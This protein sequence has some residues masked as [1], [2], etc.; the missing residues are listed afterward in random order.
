VVTTTLTGSWQR[1]TQTATTPGTLPSGNIGLFIRTNGSE[2][3]TF[4]IDNLQLEQGSSA[5]TWVVG[6]PQSGAAVLQRQA[7]IIITDTGTGTIMF[8]GYVSKLS[9]ETWRVQP[10]VKVDCHDYWQDLDRVQCNLIFNYAADTA[11]ISQVL[12]TYAPWIDTSLVNF[13]VANYT[14]PLR[15]FRAKSVMQ[16]LQTIADVV[17]FDVWVD[18]NKK[19]HYQAP[20]SMGT[21]AFAISDTPNGVSTF[22]AKFTKYEQDDNAIVNRG[23]FYGGKKASDD[24]TQNLSNQCTGS[25]T[26]FTVAY[27]PRNS[28]DGK[29]HI[30]KNGVDMVVG[31]AFGTGAAN[32]LKS[33]GGSADCILNVDA[34][35]I[36]WSTAPLANPSRHPTPH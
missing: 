6:G 26:L 36:L 5:S 1:I 16:I 25:N 24:F 23:F 2:T 4:W 32:T 17:G 35:T 33:A 12:S 20:S 19:L 31:A 27:Y 13:T 7:E 9:D 22:G 21:A 29:V 10:M 3:I 34:Q 11:I 18:A 14:F 8:G 30:K 28:S 15:R